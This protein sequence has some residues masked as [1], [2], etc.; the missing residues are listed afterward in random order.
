MKIS[1]IPLDVITTPKSGECRVGGYWIMNPAKGVLFYGQS[2]QYNYDIKVVE[3]VLSRMKADSKLSEYYKDC[4]IQHIPI[5]F[6]A[7]KDKYI[8]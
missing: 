5:A 6:L 7:H 4:V 2:P 3:I 8:D 1:Y